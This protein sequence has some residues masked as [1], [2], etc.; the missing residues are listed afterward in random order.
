MTGIQSLEARTAL[1]GLF[2][3]ASY[4]LSSSRWIHRGTRKSFDRAVNLAFIASRL[5]LYILIYFILHFGVRGDI[6]GFYVEP[7]RAALHGALPYIGYSTS[8]APLHAPLDACLLLLWNSPL[9][10]ILFAIVAECFLLPVWLRVS[11]LFLPEETV[12]RIV[13]R[14]RAD[15]ESGEWDRKYGHLRSLPAF[16]GSFRLIVRP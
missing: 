14:L 10:I 11:R 1:G 13:D 3:A 5:G 8:Y 7:A 2:A 9:V 16:E 4:I 6:P 12:C 15:I